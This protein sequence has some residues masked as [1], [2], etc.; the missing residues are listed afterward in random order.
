MSKLDH[1]IE[2]LALQPART[3]ASGPGLRFAAWVCG[4][5][6]YLGVL[7]AVVFHPRPDLADKMAQPLFAA[8]IGALGLLALASARSAVA[9]SYPDSGQKR[10]VGAAPALAAIIFCIILGLEWQADMPPAPAPGHGMECCMAISFA[11][12]PLATFMFWS[13]RRMAPLAG[14]YA[15]GAAVLAGI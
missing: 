15:G 14:G 10:D 6:W 7:V 9:L 4:M 11:A 3:P 1:L 13:I 2:G 8:E 5:L 12:V